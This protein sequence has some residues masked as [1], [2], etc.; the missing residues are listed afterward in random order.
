[1]AVEN[2]WAAEADFVLLDSSLAARLYPDSDLQ[3]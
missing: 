1:M 2:P 3:S